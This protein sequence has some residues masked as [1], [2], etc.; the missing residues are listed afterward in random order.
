MLVQT[1]TLEARVES[2]TPTSTFPPLDF[3][4]FRVRAWLIIHV[5]C[6]MLYARTHSTTTIVVTANNNPPNPPK[7]LTAICLTAVRPEGYILDAAAVADDS[8]A[9]SFLKFGSGVYI[10]WHIHFIR[11]FASYRS[12]SEAEGIRIGPGQPRC[13]SAVGRPC[14]VSHDPE[15]LPVTIDESP[16]RRRCHRRCRTQPRKPPP[17]LALLQLLLVRAP[18]FVVLDRAL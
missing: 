3:S 14:S 17:L 6:R 9:S 8:S 2:R 18:L 12:A 1:V 4:S 11:G 10:I 16:C 5:R 7:P 15:G 13:N